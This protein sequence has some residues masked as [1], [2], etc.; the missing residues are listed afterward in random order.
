MYKQD[1]SALPVHGAG[2]IH[3]ANVM[4]DASEH[5]EDQGGEFCVVSQRHA[6][7]YLQ[8][9]IASNVYLRGRSR[10]NDQIKSDPFQ[11]LARLLS[12]VPSLKGM[13]YLLLRLGAQYLAVKV[14]LEPFV[15]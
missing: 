5:K 6:R 13:T 2:T 7:Q 11:D 3:G 12:L 15:A 4:S 1:D 9:F 14:N 8:L 10:P